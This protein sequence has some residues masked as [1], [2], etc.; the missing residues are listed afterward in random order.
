M[1]SGYIAVTNTKAAEEPGDPKDPDSVSP[2]EP[3]GPVQPETPTNP[4]E[5]VTPTEPGNSTPDTPEITPSAEAPSA[6][7]DREQAS[8][9]APELPQTGDSSIYLLAAGT[10]SI[11]L[12][13]G[14][15]L[16]KKQS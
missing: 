4:E 8:S 9:E 13:A 16:A 14:I 6:G 7:G 3:V 2:E 5:P 15:G 1:L 12:L 10:G 11:I